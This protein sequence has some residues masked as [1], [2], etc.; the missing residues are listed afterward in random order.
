MSDETKCPA[1]E[2]S[3]RSGNRGPGYI[4]A[5]ECKPCHGTGKAPPQP[6]EPTPGG[7]PTFA[8]W[9]VDNGF[10]VELN[11]RDTAGMPGPS[12]RPLARYWVRLRPHAEFMTR[13]MLGGLSGDGDTPEAAVIDLARHCAGKRIAIGAYTS[14]RREIDAPGWFAP[15][16][17]NESPVPW[18]Y[19]E[20]T[21]CIVDAIGL[22]VALTDRDSAARIVRAV[23]A[24]LRPSPAASGGVARER[25]EA[26]VTKTHSQIAAGGSHA[27]LLFNLLADLEAE[28]RTIPPAAEPGEKT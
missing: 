15:D 23:N 19:D 16:P 9:M 4:I 27:G 13:G 6:V 11:E 10:T 20:S 5:N 14:E 8:A 28:A 24:S 17:G 21:S 1:C 3:G 25:V 2:G 22:N 12:G 18:H 26:L 7:S